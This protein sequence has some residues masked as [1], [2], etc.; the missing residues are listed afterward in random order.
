M[1]S[2]SGDNSESVTYK[3]DT[4]A[5]NVPVNTAVNSEDSIAAKMKM[6][7]ISKMNNKMQ[8]DT[9]NK[10]KGGAAKG[11]KGKVSITMTTP[12]AGTSMMADKEGYYSNVEVWPSYPGG[13]KALENYFANNVVYPEMAT[14]NGTQGT[15][16]VSFGVDENGKV[17][18][19]KLVGS[20]VGDGIDEEA[21]RLVSKMPKW[22]AGQ[23][24]GKAVKTRF[25]LPVRFE[26]S[27]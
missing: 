23:V 15:V 1:I 21:L 13:Q 8:G 10:M 3:A 6:D 5:A 9:A 14:N 26:L 2:C 24:K 18:S 11:K 20:K 17:V 12:A 22:T 7:S 4:S 16:Q 25:T 19:P 27:E